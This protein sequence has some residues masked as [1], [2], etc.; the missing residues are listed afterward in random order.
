VTCLLPHQPVTEASNNLPLAGE[1][2]QLEREE[3]NTRGEAW[4]QK[5]QTVQ[6][7]EERKK[8]HKYKQ[9]FGDIT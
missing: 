7:M 2:S 3:N 6:W 5:L 4:N 9:N 8:G 1:Q